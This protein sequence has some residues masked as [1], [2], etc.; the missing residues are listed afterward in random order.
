MTRTL[1]LVHGAWSGGWCWSRVRGALRERG[2]TSYAPDLP[3]HGSSEL[4]L[5]D[6]YSDAEFL[7]EYLGNLG[8]ELVLVGHSYGGAVMSEA[9]LGLDTVVHLV[10]VTGFCLE[11]GEAFL[12]L[13][14]SISQDTRM[15]GATVRP[16]GGSVVTVDSEAAIGVLFNT[17]PLPIA[18][19][20]AARLGPQS[21]ATFSQPVSGAPWRDVPSTYVRCSQD[22]AIPIDVQDAMAARCGTVRTIA[23]DH[24]PYLSAVSELTDLL[25]PIATG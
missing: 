6:L 25:I 24:S 17:T 19:D 13:R 22:R 21:V 20:A 5:G 16:D 3:G 18:L 15:A 12:P 9:A 11:E 10:Y 4:P 14:R 1:V 23:S 7:R 2:I 8:G